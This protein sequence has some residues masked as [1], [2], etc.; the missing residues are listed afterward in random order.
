VQ[1]RERRRENLVPIG[2]IRLRFGGGEVLGFAPAE[3]RLRGEAPAAALF[4]LNLEQRVAQQKRERL[5]V[6]GDVVDEKEQLETR[7]DAG[8]GQFNR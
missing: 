2:A 5:G 4:A 7:P 8:A 6:A 1:I 3:G